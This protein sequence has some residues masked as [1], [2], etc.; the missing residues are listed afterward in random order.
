MAA[1]IATVFPI[2]EGHGDVAAV[3]IL[4]RRIAAEVSTG[5]GLECLEPF[6]LSRTQLLGDSQQLTR[7]LS[8]ARLKLRDK[9]SPRFI[10]LLMDADKD[11]P[12]E[13]VRALSEQHREAF[14]LMPTSIVFAVREFEAWFLAADMSASH[15]KS[16]RAN[17]AITAEP[18]SVRGA[19]ERFEKSVMLPG[20]C[21]SES[22]DQPKY[23][24]C[25]DLVLAQRSG[26]FAKLVRE[27]RRRL[28][29]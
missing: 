20:K 23:V 7:A 6:R 26:S 1:G 3:P 22:T 17:P 12:V 10:L 13:M 28:I 8:I 27:V 14:A 18:D 25:M 19:K 4:L 16:L 29:E 11:C 24:Q 15:H 2:V 9:A 5:Y 21:Y